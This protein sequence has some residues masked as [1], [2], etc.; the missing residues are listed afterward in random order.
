[1]SKR[2]CRLAIR[3]IRDFDKRDMAAAVAATHPEIAYIDSQAHRI[4]G[5]EAVSAL[6][7]RLVSHEPSY[8]HQIDNCTPF[9]G[10]VLMRGRVLCD[11]PMLEGPTLWRVQ[12]RDR[13]IMRIQSFSDQSSVSLVRQLV[14]EAERPNQLGE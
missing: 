3:F 9:R 7:Q 12:V 13:K 5:R 1:M 10:D 11:N 14:P 8:H 4:V 2:A 6:M